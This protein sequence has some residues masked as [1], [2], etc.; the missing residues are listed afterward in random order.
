MT[1]KPHD[2]HHH[3]HGRDLYGNPEDL[4]AYLERIEASERAD[5]QKPDEVVQALELKPGQIACE[6][7]AGPGYFAL[8]LGR[9]VGEQGTVFAVEVEPRILEVLRERVAHSDLR[10]VVPVLGLAEDP[11]LPP[12]SCDLILTI[13]TF[14][15]LENGIGYLK[16]LVRSL[17]PGGRIV[18]IDFHKREMPM[19]PPA[20]LKVDRDEF[21][22]SARAAGL[23]LVAEP[24]FLE[25]QYFLVLQPK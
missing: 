12:A 7:G 3:G 24:T 23:E 13:N 14:H 2:S 22:Q 21:L 10:N 20:E 25:F 5:W 4:A 16:R 17:K 15:H 19:G 6:I 1:T 11:M 18:N 8:R 9:A